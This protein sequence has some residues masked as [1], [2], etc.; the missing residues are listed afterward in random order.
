MDVTTLFGAPKEK[1]E[2]YLTEAQRAARLQTTVLAALECTRLVQAELDAAPPLPSDA[3]R[4]VTLLIE[5]VRKI[6]ADEVVFS[7]PAKAPAAT[8]TTVA[9]TEPD[10][11][12][13]V[14]AA[15]PTTRSTHAA[16]IPRSNLGRAARA[17]N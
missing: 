13:C 5:V 12:A 14:S 1:R 17:S 4:A 6:I 11:S 7:L 16:T 9:V 10:P 3:T 8:A 15:T 2:Y